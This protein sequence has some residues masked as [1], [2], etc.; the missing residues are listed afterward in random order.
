MKLQR[1]L[2]LC[3]GNSC[4]S[5][6]AEGFA[7][8]YGKD[9]IEPHSAGLF[10]ANIVSPL[11]TQTMA[12]KNIGMGQ[13]FPKPIEAAFATGPFDVIVN[14]SGQKLPSGVAA[15]TIEDWTIRDPIG[16]SEQVFRDVA[17]QIEHLVMRL[18]LQMRAGPVEPKFDTPRPSPRQ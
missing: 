1:V 10:P 13:S 12:E 18:I 2:F 4:R 3:I 5:Q 8:T 16:E 11:T 17:N 9:V 7:R 6:M 14:I 15:P